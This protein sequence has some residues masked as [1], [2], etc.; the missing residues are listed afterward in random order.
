MSNF[1]FLVVLFKNNKKKKIINKFVTYKNAKI[2]YENLLKE[3]SQVIFAKKFENGLRSDYELS[4][5]TNQ[6]QYETQKFLKDE[7]GR[8]IKIEVENSEYKIL[9]IEK[10]SIEE[11]FWDYQ[12]KKKINTQDFIKKYLNG[13]NIKLISKLNN[14]I[15]VQNDELFDLFTFKSDQDS[16]RFTQNISKYFF[17]INK[18]DCLIVEDVSCSQRKYLYELLVEKGFSK[19]YL[20]RHSTTHP[21]KK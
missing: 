14:K 19:N 8:Q 7:Y 10:F 11:E 12:T 15:I 20:F 2:F 17:E 16:L 1:N 5:I 21:T 18:K 13:Q 4:L 9:K 6:S 3:N